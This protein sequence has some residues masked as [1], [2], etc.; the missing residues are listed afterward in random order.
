MFDTDIAKIKKNQQNVK[1]HFK[2]SGNDF[3]SETF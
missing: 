1:I 2:S 3:F